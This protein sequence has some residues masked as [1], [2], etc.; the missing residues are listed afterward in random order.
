MKLYKIKAGRSPT[1]SQI[2]LYSF[3]A[4]KLIYSCP[5]LAE[6]SL[7][8]NYSVCAASQL[9]NKK[10]LEEKDQSQVVVYQA[11]EDSKSK[12]HREGSAGILQIQ[13]CTKSPWGADPLSPKGEPRAGTG[14]VSLLLLSS[15]NS[16]WE[17]HL[18]WAWKLA[19]VT[20]NQGDMRQLLLFNASFN[21]LHY[22]VWYNHSLCF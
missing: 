10:R 9:K 15:P 8:L 12:T 2:Q 11:G 4:R 18:L 3:W 13:T 20:I 17:E 19:T 21:V 6:T 22:F 14:G 1:E 7:Y 16:F 5:S